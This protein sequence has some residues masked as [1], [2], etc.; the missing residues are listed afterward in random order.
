MHTKQWLSC[1]SLLLLGA[2]VVLAQNSMLGDTARQAVIDDIYSNPHFLPLIDLQQ[3]S[4]KL[5]DLSESF[6]QA[7]NRYTEMDEQTALL[8]DQYGDVR[9]TIEHIISDTARTKKQLKESLTA[10]SLYQNKIEDMKE[11]VVQLDADLQGTREYITD[12]AQFL[13][14]ISNDYFE[15]DLAVSTLKL[16]VKSDNIAASLSTDALVQMLLVQLE[17]LLH[18]IKKK[19]VMYANYMLNLNKT[20]LSYQSEVEQYKQDFNMLTEQ[21]KNLYELMTYIQ[22]DLTK[23]KQRMQQLSQSKLQLQNQIEN[24]KITKSAH[25]TAEIGADT[26]TY[27]LL[28]SRDRDDGNKYLTW[29]VLP[30]KNINFYFKDTNFL[31]EFDKEFP[32]ID[33]DVDQWSYVRSVAPGIVF[34]VSSHNDVS[35]NWLAIVHKYGYISFYSPMSEIRV[36]E[37][38]VVQRGQVIGRSGGEP[39]TIGAGVDSSSPH[40][41]FELLKNGE[42]IDPL[43]HLDISIFPSKNVLPDQYHVKFVQDYFAREVELAQEKIEVV[44]ESIEAR[45]DDFLQ[46]YATWP[47]RD[48]AIWYDASRNT[49]IDPLFG[50]CI[51]FAETSFKNFKSLNNIGN[52]WNNDRG[53]VVEFSSPLAGIVAMY[54]VFNNQYLGQYTTLDQLSRYGNRDGFIYAS[55]PYNRQKNIMKCLSAIHGYAIPEDY[56]IRIPVESDII[57]G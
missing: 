14:K 53:D 42:H 16:F 51:G 15:K 26:A 56:P 35:L 11:E 43:D 6:E 45:R 12:Y 3:A 27:D 36:K 44:G 30:V 20:K 9:I 40:L 39:G 34:K 52:V 47:Y 31:Q 50:M 49:W 21:K 19:Q 41:Q 5:S 13:Y 48:P 1:G 2:G 29:P 28:N 17:E 57:D 55:S 10:I 32:G 23:A 18:T 37:G 7:Q 4:V 25:A 33:I 24:I 38:E 22:G 54:S 46:R 8:E